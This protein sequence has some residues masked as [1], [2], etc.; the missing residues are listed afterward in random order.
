MIEN[1]YRRKLRTRPFNCD[2][3]IL[4][5]CQIRDQEWPGS[6]GRLCVARYAGSQWCRYLGSVDAC[7]S[8]GAELAGPTLTSAAPGDHALGTTRAEICRC[9]SCCRL[10]QRPVGSADGWA[11]AGADASADYLLGWQPLPSPWVLVN[12]GE[13]AALESELLAEVSQGHPLSGNR[14]TAIARCE[15]CDEVVFSVGDSAGFV[16]VHLTWRRAPE[17]PP[18]PTTE[19]LGMPLS[20]GLASHDH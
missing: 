16:S 11:D 3:D 4:D 20:R 9:A 7:P 19:R 13:R 14:V 18:W 10:A 2:L 12:A 1:Q 15:G 6:G 5:L 17:P 8:C